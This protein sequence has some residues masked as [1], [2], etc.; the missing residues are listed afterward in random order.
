MS[1]RMHRYLN[2]RAT[3][4]RQT[5]TDNYGVPE[6]TTDMIDCRIEKRIRLTQD[7]SGRDVTSTMTV[8]IAP[9]EGVSDCA[10]LM[11]DTINGMPILSV[12]QMT[13]A[14][15]EIIGYEVML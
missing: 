5:G 7:Q 4:G 2:Q 1:G 10:D 11:G 15:G 9:Q 13:D 12:T 6:R 8:Y 3:W 14:H